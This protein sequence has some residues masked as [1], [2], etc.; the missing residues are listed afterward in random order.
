MAWRF[1]AREAGVHVRHGDLVDR[2]GQEAHEVLADVGVQHADRAQRAGVPGD[3]DPF[4]AETPRHRRAVHRARAAGRDQRETPGRVAAFY[5]DVLDGVEHVLFDEVDDAGRGLVDRESERLGDLGPDRIA[6]GFEV[7]V[8]GAAR[9]PSGA[10]SAEH[11]LRVRDGGPAP[12]LPVAGRTRIGAGPFRPDVQE[13]GVVHPREGAA[14]RADGVDVDGGGRDVVARDHDVVPG[15]HRAARHQEHVAGRAPDFHGDQVAGEGGVCGLAVDGLPVQVQRPDRGG[16]TAEQEIDRALGELPDGGGAAVRLQQEDRTGEPQRGEFGVE[17]V[18]VGGDARQ[19]GRV[20]HRCRRPLV[21]AHAR[22]D[23]RG[24][25]GPVPRPPVR[26]GTGDRA[27]VRV[28]EEAVQQGHRDGLDVLR[29]EVRSDRV[30]T[31]EIERLDLRAGGVDAARDRLAQVARHQHG[32][33]GRPVVELVLPQAAADLEGVPKA[34]GG[35]QAHP[36][37]LALEERVRRDGR[38]VHEQG[39]RC[40]EFPHGHAKVPGEPR[41]RRDDPAARVRGDGRH[42]GDPGRAV[43][44]RQHEIGEGAA[45][46]DAD[47]PGRR[48]HACGRVG[49]GV[50]QSVTKHSTRSSMLRRAGEAGS[51]SGFAKALWGHAFPITPSESYAFR[52]STSSGV[53]RG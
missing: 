22:R 45:D 31:G 43:C 47:A 34:L 38:T 7:Q 5:R 36:G 23:R 14:A 52:T 37:A 28:V 39:A 17:G 49:Q 41:E 18:Q 10:Q 32:S 15:R 25:R 29:L 16:G 2:T 33:V 8:E 9:R 26:E 30:Q 53:M 44:V 20:D 35:D 6:G 13:S 50:R 48:R 3:V 40:E 42:L 19:E 1:E 51:A 21:L 11:E 46:V 27:L 4:A 24:G 12:A